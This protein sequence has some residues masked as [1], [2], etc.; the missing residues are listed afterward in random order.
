MQMIVYK[1]KF[2][3]IYVDKNPFW[4]DFLYRLILILLSWVLTVINRFADFFIKT[5]FVTIA[6]NF[7]ANKMIFYTNCEI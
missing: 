5:P 1:N 4:L 3:N 7:P 2:M 6:I